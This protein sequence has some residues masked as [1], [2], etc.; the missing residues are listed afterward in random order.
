MQKNIVLL[1]DGT[2]NSASKLFKTNVWRL[3]EALDLNEQD[4]IASFSDGVGT[5]SF[6]PFEIIGLALGFGV[7]RRVIGLYKFLSLN[8]QPGD[9]IY[10][11]G[12]SRG[13]F[14]IRVLVGLVA[15]EGLVDFQ[16][17]EELDRNALAVYRA[18]RKKAFPSQLPWTCWGRRLRDAVVGR[19]NKLTGSRSYEEVRPRS[20]PRSAEEIKIAFVGVWDTVAAY[21]LPIDE[22]TQAVD[23]WIWPLTFEKSRLLPCVERARQALSL[24]DERRTFFPIPWSPT[25]DAGNEIDPDR[26]R[27]LWFAGV[28]SNIGGGYPDDRL[29]HVPLL[30]MIEEARNAGLRFKSDTVA[31]QADFA[32]ENGRIYDSRANLGFFYRYHPRDCKS[33]LGELAPVVDWS[34]LLRMADGPDGYAPVSLPLDFRIH[35]PNGAIVPFLA[36][37]TTAASSPD[38]TPLQLRA[39]TALVEMRRRRPAD[40][41]VHLER[42]AVM[43]DTV[44]WRR[45]VYY[46][47][48]F[49]VLLVACYPL[50][51]DYISSGAI[52]TIESGAG[53]IVGRLTGIVE[54][55]APGFAMPWLNAIARNPASA[56][57]LAG[58]VAGTMWLS[59]FLRT[60]IADR[61]RIAWCSGRWRRDQR[62]FESER[63]ESHK[64]VAAAAAFISS[65]AAIAAF[66]TGTRNAAAL[67][68]ATALLCFLGMIRVTSKRRRLTSSAFLKCARLVR[69]N[70]RM[71]A[72]YRALR[73]HIFPALALTTTGLFALF[74]LNKASF[75]VASAAG[76]FC[77]KDDPPN[78]RAEL[79]E[80]GPGAFN[81]TSMCW[82]TQLVLL[83]G[84]RYR[85]ALEIPPGSAFKDDSLR[86]GAAGMSIQ[87]LSQAVRVPLRRWWG[88]PYFQLIARIGSR[89]ADEQPATPIRLK[90]D[91]PEEI[92]HAAFL[93]TPR[94]TG[95]LY[96]YL[97]DAALGI[98]GLYD[99][100]YQNNSGAARVTVENV[101][102]Y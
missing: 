67:F 7:K 96:L 48:L 56:A 41:A 90:A 68:A 95:R 29:A 30:W 54:L 20:G 1:A 40:N 91:R 94:E 75:D 28:H 31:R 69:T 58:L 19:W 47:L 71:I 2:G 100:F 102:G 24:D 44:W 101:S 36:P 37:Q 46:V 14:I 66:T 49:L 70:A 21:G 53:P 93:F 34:V 88:Q 38:S 86:S 3:Y 52:N 63:D 77:A 42:F 25:D 35:M 51:S 74:L 16:S 45:A 9:R 78:E 89:G 32:S 99:F 82:D 5:S 97:N 22:L 64:R 85:I 23:R 27:Q 57:I 79:L 11:F 17:H 92:S 81:P 13:A 26:L 33:L 62:L 12:F 72:V 8:Y 84:E 6:K 65:V 50:F 98:P 39:E 10:A 80:G 87:S 60:R 59:A 76:A 4:Q 73:E 15:R 43:H 55:F 18:Y 61:A 83:K